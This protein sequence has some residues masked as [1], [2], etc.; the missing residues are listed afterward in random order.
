VEV[1]YGRGARKINVLPIKGF[2]SGVKKNSSGTALKMQQ[3][4]FAYTM[5]F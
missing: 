1:L 5:S 2:P 3:L 4:M